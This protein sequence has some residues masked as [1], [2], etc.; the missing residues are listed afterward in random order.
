MLTRARRNRGSIYSLS[1]NGGEVKGYMGLGPV[2]V[3]TH[4]AYV[5]SLPVVRWLAAVRTS[6]RRQTSDVL[7]MSRCHRI[8]RRCRS[9]GRW[10]LSDVRCRVIRPVVV[11]CRTSG[12]FR[13]SGS[14]R[15]RSSVFFRLRFHA[16][17]ADNVVVQL[18]LHSSSSSIPFRQYLCMHTSGVSSSIPSSKGSS[19]HV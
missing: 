2:T 18:R 1:A 6:G 12:V 9:S 3:H 5:R 17:L 19:K 4:A 11:E 8:S 7:P 10:R 16:S 13:S 14:C 15:L